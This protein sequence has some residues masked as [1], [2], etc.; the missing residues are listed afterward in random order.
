MRRFSGFKGKPRSKLQNSTA[1]RA[2]PG[3]TACGP[4]VIWNW[5]PLEA[6]VI[7]AQAGIHLI[8]K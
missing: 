6:A 4:G 7:P 5:T 3:F 8:A 2:L 1:G